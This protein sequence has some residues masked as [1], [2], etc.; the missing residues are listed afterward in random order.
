MVAKQSILLASKVMK[1]YFGFLL[2]ILELVPL[3]SRRYKLCTECEQN[4][5]S[6]FT[7]YLQTDLQPVHFAAN[8][9][10]LNIL[11]DE[12]H[13]NPHAKASVTHFLNNNVLFVQLHARLCL[14]T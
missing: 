7:T 13:Y 1:N 5:D 8:E 14:Y 3:L 9:T 11:V 6:L 2:K 12:Y 10:I 4:Y